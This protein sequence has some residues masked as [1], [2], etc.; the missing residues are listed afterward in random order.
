[1]TCLFREPLQGMRGAA[2]RWCTAPAGSLLSHR[3]GATEQWSNGP[4]HDVSLEVRLLDVS[5]G[6]YLE[7]KSRLQLRTY[8]RRGDETGYL[9]AVRVLSVSG[10]SMDCTAHGPVTLLSNVPRMSLYFGIIS[11]LFWKSER[12]VE[13]PAIHHLCPRHRPMLI[14]KRVFNINSRSYQS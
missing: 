8:V 1:M 4:Q 6:P 13:W 3:P 12:T 9:T 10:N 11:Y 5:S 14:K 7:G 2:S